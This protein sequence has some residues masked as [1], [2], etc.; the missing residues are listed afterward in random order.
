MIRFLTDATGGSAKTRLLKRPLGRD[1]LA[2]SEISLSTIPGAREPGVQRKAA[3]SVIVIRSGSSIGARFVLAAGRPA[4]SF[5]SY[6]RRFHP[7]GR[8]SAAFATA[9][10]QALQRKDG[11]FEL[12]AFPTQFSEH[13]E[14]VHGSQH[15]APTAGDAKPS[16]WSGWSTLRLESLR[17]IEAPK[18]RHASLRL[19]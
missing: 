9:C 13:V 14:D 19:R 2:A 5:R 3:R 18:W 12:V 11:F 17:L 16:L 6:F 10:C 1:Y 8:P 7:L 15:T 4:A